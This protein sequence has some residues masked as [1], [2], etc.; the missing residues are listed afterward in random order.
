MGQQGIEPLGQ[1]AQA[2]GCK[3]CD[4]L[5]QDAEVQGFALQALSLATWA[6]LFDHKIIG[7]TLQGFALAFVLLGL[8]ESDES[9]VLNV[10]FTRHADRL[11]CRR[12]GLLVSMHNSVLALFRNLLPGGVQIKAKANA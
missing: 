11:I 6:D 4:A 8:N 9:F 10:D 3:I 12:E 2:H 5:V 7:P 1:I